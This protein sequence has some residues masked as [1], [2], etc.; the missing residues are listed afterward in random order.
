MLTA[1]GFGALLSH[2]H[3]DTHTD[4]HTHTHRH[5]DTHTHILEQRDASE[6]TEQITTATV[7]NQTTSSSSLTADC[8]N[9]HFTILEVSERETD[10]VGH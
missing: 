6:I 1:L 3:T 5:T 9:S 4:T 7:I 10:N 8:A 2:T